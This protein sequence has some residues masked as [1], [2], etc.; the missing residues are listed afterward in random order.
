MIRRGRFNKK[1]NAVGMNDMN[2]DD[3]YASAYYLY[4]ISE[5]LYQSSDEI[6]DF[7]DHGSLYI[8]HIRLFLNLAKH[9]EK[10]DD[11]SK[12]LVKTV[13]KAEEKGI[14]TRLSQNENTEDEVGNSRTHRLTRYSRDIY[15]D[16]SDIPYEYTE[17]HSIDRNLPSREFK[18]TPLIINLYRCL[19]AMEDS[20]NFFARLIANFL[21][22]KEETPNFSMLEAVPSYVKRAL[23]NNRKVAFLGKALNLTKKEVSE[24]SEPF[25]GCIKTI[26]KENSLLIN[27]KSKMRE[28]VSKS[29]DTRALNASMNPE[30]IVR[31]IRNA[32]RFSEENQRGA[33]ASEN[34]IRMLFYGLSGTGKTE[35]ARYIAEKLNKKILLKRASDILDKYIGGSEQ[36]IRESFEEADRTGSILLFDEADSFFADR[37]GAEHNWERIQVNEFLTQMEEFGGILICTTNLKKIMDSAMNRRFHMIVQFKPLNADGIRCMLD[38]YFHSFSF[39]D[40]EIH[41]LECRSSITPGDF[42]VLASRMRFMD[43][44]SLNTSYIINE[45]CAIQDDKNDSGSSNKIGFAM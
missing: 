9:M 33:H 8:P 3:C 34:G 18:I 12:F 5:L 43:K 41:R 24:E 13:D 20:Y 25:L 45:L 17:D 40:E 27:G 32:Q 19:F 2:Q 38:R 37:N 26:L 23:N 31:M 16:D 29:Y 14:L 7:D 10:L 6:S 22:L 1:N 4:C 21:L 15:F 35:F 42:G 30:K 44:E 39:S 36:N 11:I 28:T